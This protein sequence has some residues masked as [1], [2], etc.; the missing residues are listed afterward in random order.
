MTAR[1]AFAGLVR[2]GTFPLLAFGPSA[3][4]LTLLGPSATAHERPSSTILAASAATIVG[5]YVLLAMLERLFPHRD[6]WNRPK[7]DL[8]ADLA[9]FVALAPASALLGG[10]LASLL[11][12][13]L[14]R[15]SPA[16]LRLE[17][18]P[19]AWFPFLQVFLACWLAELGHY[20][21]HRLGHELPLL[22]RLHSIHHSAR[23]LYWLNAT[24]FHPLDLMLL[25]FLQALPLELLGIPPGIYLAYFVASSC[26]G[27]LQHGNVD[28]DTRLFSHLFATPELHRWHHSRH[29]EE[30]NTNY[31]AI[32]IFWD[33]LFRTR[34]WPGK[35]ITEPVGIG[36]MPRFPDHL[37][38]QLL[39]PF[40]WQRVVRAASSDGAASTESPLP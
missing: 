36:D 25:G 39:A 27:Q 22:W 24:R 26:Y 18:W 13:A 5:S 6:D 37:L 15:G 12:D 23:R 8:L 9:Y 4:V 2:H 35:P 28:V 30:G 40:R 17:V 19:E 31:G 20:W 14:H 29:P 3:L 33:Q 7:D 32:L 10:T 38:D 11:V 21:A 34:F 16:T 1:R